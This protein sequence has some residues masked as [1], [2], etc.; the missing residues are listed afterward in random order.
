[1]GVQIFIENDKDQSLKTQYDCMCCSYDEKNSPIPAPGC[2][3]C[4]GTG[5]IV[6][7]RS[8]WE[9]SVS[10]STLCQMW[11]TLGLENAVDPD[12]VPC[13]IITAQ[14]IL[15]AI[16]NYNGFDFKTLNYAT[17]LRNIA[18]QAVTLGKPVCWC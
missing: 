3:E 11:A 10:A 6:F 17:K 1:M 8:Q 4:K 2:T 13:G 12:G 9:I 15:E 18:R 5:K 7:F 14:T 16:N